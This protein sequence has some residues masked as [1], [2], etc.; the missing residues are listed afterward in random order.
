MVK[1]KE[2]PDLPKSDLIMPA[3]VRGGFGTSANVPSTGQG[4]VE[5]YD[6]TVVQVKAGEDLPMLAKRLYG[7]EKYAAALEEY[8]KL[9]DPKQLNLQTGQSVRVPPLEL[10]HKKFGRLIDGHDVADKPKA[11]SNLTSGPRG[12]NSTTQPLVRTSNPPP[13]QGGSGDP[14][15]RYRVREQDTI[16]MIAKKTL[17]NSD[18]WAEIYNLNR[19]LLSGSTQLKVGMVL[20]LPSD[21]KVDIQP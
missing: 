17:G 11:H 3:P 1:I 10:L 7:S 9:Y 13:N 12:S 4:Q 20:R 21:A 5:V 2:Q 18:R 16:W 6:I 8:L 14:Y 19:D 15:I